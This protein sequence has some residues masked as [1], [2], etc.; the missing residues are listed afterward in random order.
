MDN[1]QQ[2]QEKYLSEIEAVIVRFLEEHTSDQTLKD[3]M[4]YSIHAGGKRIRPLLLTS[5]VASFHNS[6]TLVVY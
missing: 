5:T 1:M 6:M 2:F 4:L 3:S